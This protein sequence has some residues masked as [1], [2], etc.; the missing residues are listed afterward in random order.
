MRVWV[1]SIATEELIES[2]IRSSHEPMSKVYLLHVDADCPGDPKWS[3]GDIRS[4][5]I[6]EC[7]AGYALINLYDDGTF[8]NE[9][10]PF[11]WAYRPDAPAAE[12]A[13]K[14]AAAGGFPVGRGQNCL[15]LSDHT[16]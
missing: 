10:V 6:D 15:T 13:S 16:A 5:H 4:G 2:R 11:G 14:P 1:E 9:Y 8:E 12:P 3:S 7:D